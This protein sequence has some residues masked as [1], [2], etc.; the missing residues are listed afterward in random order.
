MSAIQS[1]MTER[2][3]PDFFA[4]TG[5]K[6]SSAGWICLVMPRR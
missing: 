6:S 3:Y 4:T 2:T 5:N 1:H